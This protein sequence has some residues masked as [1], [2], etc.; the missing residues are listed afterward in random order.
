MRVLQV[1]AG[2]RHG[3][4]ELFF[5]RLTLAL[6]RAG[7]QQQAAIRTAPDR[8][9]KLRAAGI[10]T[11]EMRFGGWL[12]FT[13]RPALR[14]LIADY[15]PDVALSWMSRATQKFPRRNS[16]ETRPVHCA[17]LGGYYPLKY[18]RHCDHLIGNT[19]DI[20]DYTVSQGWPAARAHYLPNFVDAAS[21]PP[22]P[23]DIF[24]TEMNAPLL[25]AM[26]R[27]HQHKGFDILLAALARLPGV[28]LWIAGEGPEEQALRTQAGRLGVAGR[29]RFL[30]WRE[31]APALMA[32]A[33]ILVCPSRIE[34]LG[35]VVIEAWAQG[36][37]VVAARAQGPAA[38]IRGGV[39]GM[40]AECEDVHGLAQ[41]IGN[42]L[43]SPALAA[44]LAAA[45]RKAYE[46]DFTE[47]AVVARYLE[48]FNKV[49][50]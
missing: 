20:V 5:E 35:N 29:V 46:Q 18:Y 47:P 28:Y 27:L 43:A 12:D 19:Q 9:G 50:A 10:E 48:F 49:I 21:A 26:G 15:Q 31:D 34:P 30:G 41:A 42:V 4:A 45:G 33:N 44:G 17:R 7:V 16:G 23:R 6:D 36:L 3:G 13:T 25:L 1:M 38:L 14:R 2:A 11:Y 24:S 39:T 37:P 32:A 8:A 40:L 22:L